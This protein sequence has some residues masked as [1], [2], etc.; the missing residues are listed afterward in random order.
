MTRTI[1]RLIIAAISWGAV[2]APFSGCDDGPH[3]ACLYSVTDH[4]ETTNICYE[5]AAAARCQQTYG[6]FHAVAGCSKYPPRICPE[7]LSRTP[8]CPGPACVSSAQVTPFC[9]TRRRAV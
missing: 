3:G 5:E 4:T 1:R 9:R 8:L 2:A 6:E 7:F